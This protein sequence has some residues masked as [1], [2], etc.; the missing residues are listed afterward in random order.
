MTSG[1]NDLLRRQWNGW[2]GDGCWVV[3]QSR[4]S[5]RALF[6]N[7]FSLSLSFN[8]YFPPR[9]VSSPHLLADVFFLPVLLVKMKE[10]KWKYPLGH[11]AVDWW[12]RGTL[13]CLSSNL[14]NFRV[15]AQPTHTRGFV[16]RHSSFR[17]LMIGSIPAEVSSAIQLSGS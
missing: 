3:A 16:K 7:F 15:R 4:V 10:R 11:K 14:H 5:L 17:L 6:D 8:P 12:W 2:N 13:S 9:A 1:E